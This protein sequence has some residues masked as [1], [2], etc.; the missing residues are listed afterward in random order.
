MTVQLAT[1]FIKV[2][3]SVEVQTTE[4]K[5]EINRLQSGIDTYNSLTNN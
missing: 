1:K 4:I 5:K 2:L 3:E